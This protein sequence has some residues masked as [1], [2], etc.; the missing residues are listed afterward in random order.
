MILF[1]RI[2]LITTLALFA[3]TSS[4]QTKGIELTIKEPGK[5]QLAELF[6][7]ADTV[8]LV[9]VVAGDTEKYSAVVYKA[10]VLRTFKG[11]AAGSTIFFGPYAGTRLGWEY[12][13]F[14]RDVNKKITTRR[15]AEGEE[16]VTRYAE[17][18]NE[19]YSEM[20]TSYECVFDGNEISRKCDY[21]VRVCTDYVKLPKSTPTFPPEGE[22]TS[23]GCRWVRKSVFIPILERLSNSGK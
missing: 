2:S 18:F 15:A 10:R 9:K 3:H 4:A 11:A 7:Q 12:I 16:Q 22:E 14:L 21:G 23:F 1:R 8:A 5:Y 20:M 19:G 6:K 13:V 17:V